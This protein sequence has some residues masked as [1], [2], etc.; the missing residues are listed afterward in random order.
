[1]ITPSHV[2]AHMGNAARGMKEYMSN[3]IIVKWH[4]RD[5]KTFLS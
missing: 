5:T 4:L 1:M 3:T 2:T